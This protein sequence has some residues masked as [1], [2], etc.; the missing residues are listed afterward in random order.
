[1][2]AIISCGGDADTNAAMVGGIVGASVGIEGIP[3][4]W[5]D[6][7]CLFPMS[8]QSIDELSTQLNQTRESGSTGSSA[9]PLWI[10][11]LLRNLSFLVVVLIHGFRRLGP[12]Y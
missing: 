9:S 8:M 12:P 5:I 2:E 3:S 11:V 4:Q 1:M 7:L 10:A 6:R